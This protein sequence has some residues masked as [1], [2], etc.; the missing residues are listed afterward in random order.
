MALDDMEAGKYSRRWRHH[1][2]KRAGRRGLVLPM[3]FGVAKALAL[4]ARS[5]ER[6]ETRPRQD[7]IVGRV[8]RDQG[9]GI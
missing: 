5:G 6:R 3:I 4:K 9:V 2:K 1:E 7:Q 8:C